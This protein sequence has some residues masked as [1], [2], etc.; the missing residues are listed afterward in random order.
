MQE[1]KGEEN[2][3]PIE[4]LKLV[5]QSIGPRPAIDAIDVV[6]L[7]VPMTYQNEIIFF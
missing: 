1:G 3:V 6:S 4:K 2:C 5:H 7:K